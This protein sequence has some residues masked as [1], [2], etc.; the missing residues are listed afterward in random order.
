MHDALVLLYA[1]VYAYIAMSE[2]E[3]LCLTEPGSKMHGTGAGPER[4]SA[5][6]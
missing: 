3:L 2:R 4:S 6:G 5:A 1:E